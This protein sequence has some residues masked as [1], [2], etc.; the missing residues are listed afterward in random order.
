MAANVHRQPVEQPMSYDQYMEDLRSL[1][2]TDDIMRLVAEAPDETREIL[3]ISILEEAIAYQDNQMALSLAGG[4]TTSQ[5]E[6]LSTPV[7]NPF[8]SARVPDRAP[9]QAVRGS[10]S[11]Q[12]RSRPGGQQQS[13]EASGEQPGES[14]DRRECVACQESV[15]GFD[16]TSVPCGHDYCK[17]C[18]RHLFT[19]ALD[20][21]S[22]FPPR[23]CNQ[24]IPA[25]SAGPFLSEALRGS[26]DEK[27]VEFNTSDKTYCSRASCSAFV[28]SSNIA[29]EIAMCPRC[30]TR[31][32]TI[33]KAKAHEGR[34]CPRDTGL[35]D[36]LNMAAKEG[37]QRCYRCGR[38]TELMD[39]CNTV[40]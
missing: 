36:V 9:Q 39:G 10:N 28:P 33:C 23:C 8:A 13:A 14:N 31:T 2:I 18:I 20:D 1:V 16:L 4:D 32:C 19:A 37:W 26:F 34:D 12:R 6:L 17:D 21:E 29:H 15:V 5:F 24:A 35:Q 22:L 3:A 38:M 11:G 7:S 30:R 40:M 25:S 27:L